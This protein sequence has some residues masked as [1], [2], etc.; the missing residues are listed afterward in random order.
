MTNPSFVRAFGLVGFDFLSELLLNSILT[1]LLQASGTS[2]SILS[3]KKPL[4]S[5]GRQSL[6]KAPFRP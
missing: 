2:F 5:S 6:C 4:F 3:A 1:L